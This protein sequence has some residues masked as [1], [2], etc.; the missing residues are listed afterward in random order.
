M[1]GSPMTSHDTR[2]LQHLPGSQKYPAHGSIYRAFALPLP[3]DGIKAQSHRH[4]RIK[5]A[6]TSTEEATLLA[7]IGASV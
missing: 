5:L 6:A 2:A 4:I 7:T 1:P 3:G